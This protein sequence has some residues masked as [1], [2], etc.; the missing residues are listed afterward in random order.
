MGWLVCK[1]QNLNKE[2]LKYLFDVYTPLY[3][4]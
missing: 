4:E 2:E 3:A 1:I